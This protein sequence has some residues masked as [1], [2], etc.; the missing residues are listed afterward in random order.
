MND[1]FERSP[2]QIE[3]DI[4][5]TRSEMSRTLNALQRKLSPGQVVDGVLSQFA[6]GSGEF[7][8]GL[9]RTVRANPVPVTLMGIGLGW[10]M[11]SAGRSPSDPVGGRSATVD[12]RESNTAERS[13]DR[14]LTSVAKGTGRRVRDMADTVRGKADGLRDNA[15]RMGGRA[16]V[17]AE[18]AQREVGRI[19]NRQPLLLGALGLTIG[20][21]LGASLPATRRENALLGETRDRLKDKAVESGKRRLGE[22]RPVLDAAVQ[23]AKGE[24]ERLGMIAEPDD[25][26]RDRESAKPAGDGTPKKTEPAVPTT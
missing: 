1:A 16:R 15:A 10:L 19:V 24:A 17:R 14:R 6:S 22:A 12:H 21:A 2:S 13:E 9:A 23:S 4:A 25:R 11:V 7:A 3:E 18:Q 8:G 5:R 26:S 20:V